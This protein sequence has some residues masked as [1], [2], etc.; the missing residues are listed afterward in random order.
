MSESPLRQSHERLLFCDAYF[1]AVGAEQLCARPMYREYRLPTD[2]DKALTDRPFFWLWAEKTNQQVEPTTLRL[3]FDAVAKDHEDAILRQQFE[4]EREIHPPQTRYE[5]M[6]QRPKQTE[7]INLGC[8]R[9]DKILDSVRQRGE[10]VVAIPKNSSTREQFIPWLMMNGIVQYRADSIQEVWFSLGVC[11]GNLQIVPDF[12]QRIEHISMCICDP[13]QLLQQV[14]NTP[15]AAIEVI[16]HW[17]EKDISERDHAWASDAK[18]RLQ[19]DLSQLDAYYES[20]T[21]GRADDERVNLEA[22]H[23]RKRTEL[24]NKST[25]HIRVEPTQI[26]LIGLPLR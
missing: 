15:D 16:K 17:L 11:L 23:Q 2:V 14:K 18:M 12:F 1:E 26:G 10:F 20:I 4:R 5:M 19:D 24:I 6:F 22:E 13:K 21:H 3:A 9:L 8:F 7:L 25:P